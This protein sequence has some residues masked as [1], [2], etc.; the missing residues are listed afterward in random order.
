[1]SASRSTS[2]PAPSWQPHFR[3]AINRSI[4]KYL[5]RHPTSLCS[6]RSFKVPTALIWW[7]PAHGSIYPWAIP[8]PFHGVC[9]SWI[10]KVMR[11]SSTR[12]ITSAG[13]EAEPGRSRRISGGLWNQSGSN[14]LA[15]VRKQLSR[16]VGSPGLEY[17]S[18]KRLPPV[19]QHHGRNGLCAAD[20]CWTG[21]RYR[22]CLS[23]QLP[24]ACGCFP[25]RNQQLTFGRT[26]GISSFGQ[27]LSRDGTGQ[28]F[29]EF[30]S[31]PA[32]LPIQGK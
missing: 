26:L 7:T 27:S 18:T 12:R 13:D 16:A 24:G 6:C 15:T 8:R 20:V 1:M 19:G 25:A 9:F 4:S 28:A 23:D 11:S 32:V 21:A 10:R 30:T 17:C 2:V 5:G 22:R 14:P 3:K 29:E 31:R